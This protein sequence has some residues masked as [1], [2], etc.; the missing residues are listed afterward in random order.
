M[1]KSPFLVELTML[2]MASF[3]YTPY[4]CTEVSANQNTTSQQSADSAEKEVPQ[5]IVHTFITSAQEVGGFIDAIDTFTSD[6]AIKEKTMALR[7]A[8]N[9]LLQSIAQCKSME[10]AELITKKITA[11]QNHLKK[12]ISSN[13]Q[14]FP[15]FDI[16]DTAHITINTDTI[17][18][19][20]TNST[21]IKSL[22]PYM[23]LKGY[24]IAYRTCGAPMRNFVH[25]YGLP[26]VALATVVTYL[27]WE[28]GAEDSYLHELFGLPKKDAGDVLANAL[29]PQQGNPVANEEVEGAGVGVE[30]NKKFPRLDNVPDAGA[31]K[32][33]ITP[34]VPLLLS[35]AFLEK[36]TTPLFSSTP[37]G[38][39]KAICFQEAVK[40]LFR[41]AAVPAFN[42][43]LQKEADLHHFLLGG[44]ALK[45]YEKMKS[46]NL[47]SSPVPIAT[48]FKDVIGC[49]DAVA[50]CKQVIEDFKH[51]RSTPEKGL[52]LFGP[53]GT[54]KSLIARA[55][56][57]ELQDATGGKVG[58]ISV[59]RHMI[60]THGLE[61]ITNAIKYAGSCVVFFD[62]MN[63]LGLT[64]KEASSLSSFLH[65]TNLLQTEDPKK[66]I[67]LIGA[68]NKIDFYDAV[69]RRGRF[70]KTLYIDLPTYQE[71]YHFLSQKLRP[72]VDQEEFE[73][74][75]K[76]AA[77]LTSTNILE[78]LHALVNN[79]LLLK[80]I[81]KENMLSPQTF[82]NAIFETIFHIPLAPHMNLSNSA[83]LA[84]A[85]HMAGHTIA[86]L[87]LE[88]DKLFSCVTLKPIVTKPAKLPEQQKELGLGQ[89]YGGMFPPISGSLDGITVTELKK[90][91]MILL[92]GG[93]GSK[94]LIGETH[95]SDTRTCSGIC[96]PQA[97]DVAKK[98]VLNGLTESQLSKKDAENMLSDASDLVK[99]LESETLDLLDKNKDKVKF[100]YLLLLKYKTVVPAHIEPIMNEIAQA[101]AEQQT[102]EEIQ[103]EQSKADHEENIHE[104]DHE[105]FNTRNDVM[106]EQEAAFKERMQSA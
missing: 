7:Y 23:G 18:S 6:D 37:A 60:D 24:N 86:R 3:A 59:T 50:Y 57:G 21:Q 73:P 47:L 19:L 106:P 103:K 5:E 79:A 34:D 45:Q 63:L 20:T 85:M 74:M 49:E 38:F 31:S 67:I 102:R 65:S 101:I 8:N 93:L 81:R 64:E 9:R 84:H 62:E 55:L 91:I 104:M 2:I 16:N 14:D 88:P 39:V 29:N 77:E 27:A 17:K 80:T 43:A 26:I 83:M 75:L 52:F 4:S 95:S 36:I 46:R 53:P 89:I 33:D 100:T 70:G 12:I 99:K 105:S 1:K 68:A 28:Y 82:E 56:A 51:Q 87:A 61:A 54:G 92:A 90:K 72:Y 66:Q 10:E 42:V 71:R 97:F 40:Y 44:D 69:L 13:T 48:R 78:D 98:I 25:T 94:V 22:I 41:E 15:D 58:Y 30:A 11:F 96:K 32:K 35:L 76:Y